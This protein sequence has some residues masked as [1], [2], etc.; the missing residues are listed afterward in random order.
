LFEE[1]APVLLAF[2]ARGPRILWRSPAD[3]LVLRCELI[4]HLIDEDFEVMAGLFRRN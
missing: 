1:I 4:G 3:P 2:V